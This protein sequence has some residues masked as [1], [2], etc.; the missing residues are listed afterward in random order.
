MSNQ[1]FKAF[2]NA[3]KL[4]HLNNERLYLAVGPGVKVDSKL[5]KFK[6]HSDNRQYT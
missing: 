4:R 6:L 5:Q 1:N 2:S 3:P